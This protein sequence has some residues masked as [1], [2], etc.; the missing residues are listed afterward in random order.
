MSA[1]WWQLQQQLEYRQWLA[2]KAGIAEYESWLKKLDAIPD[3]R[4]D[5]EP[6]TAEVA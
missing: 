1:D 4:K 3:P 5:H 2:D 6:R